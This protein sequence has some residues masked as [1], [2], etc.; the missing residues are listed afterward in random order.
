MTGI[1]YER[2]C[3]G[4][5]E[6]CKPYG[7]GVMELSLKPIDSNI[8]PVTRYVAEYGCSNC[9]Q[10]N[11]FEVDNAHVNYFKDLDRE[12]QTREVMDPTWECKDCEHKYD[13]HSQLN[14]LGANEVN[15][16]REQNCKCMKF[17]FVKSSTE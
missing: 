11:F 12:R 6:I 10:L 15:G 4:C 16:K 13:V 8:N 14:C 3:S 1:L 17:A 9:D 7:F 2:K 5:G